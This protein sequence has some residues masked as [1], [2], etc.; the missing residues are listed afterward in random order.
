LVRHSSNSGGNSGDGGDSKNTP[1]FKAIW[2]LTPRYARALP[3]ALVAG[4]PKI[5]FVGLLQRPSWQATPQQRALRAWKDA[6]F[7]V[8]RDAK[9]VETLLLLTSYDAAAA[10]DSTAPGAA[11]EEK[12]GVTTPV[13][14]PRRPL[15]P[16][17]NGRTRRGPRQAAAAGGPAQGGA[18]P[19]PAVA[20]EAEAAGATEAE[21]ASASSAPAS[22]LDPS[23]AEALRRLRADDAGGGV[24][25]WLLGQL[26][27][28][29]STAAPPTAAPVPSQ[30]AFPVGPF[31]FP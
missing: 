5:T 20:A 29:A 22:A 13:G 18:A 12:G 30:P 15:V 24:L 28:T 6:R 4:L 31:P 14:R 11:S 8:A 17:L 26:R 16:G 2:G 27:L 23:K 25:E 19:P 10:P 3:P 1:R 21:A 7:A 9:P